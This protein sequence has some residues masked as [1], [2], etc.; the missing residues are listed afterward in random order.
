MVGAI[1]A[2]FALCVRLI[3]LARVRLS[4]YQLLNADVLYLSHD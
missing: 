4:R 1:W 3:W 2:G